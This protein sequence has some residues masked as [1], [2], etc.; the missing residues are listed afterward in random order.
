MRHK[1]IVVE[2]SSKNKVI[3]MTSQ[4]E[5]VKIPFKK[6]VHVGQE[7]RYKPGKERLNVWQLGLAVTLFLAMVGTW[8]IFSQQFFPA[9]MTPAYI[10]TL[11]FQSSLELQVDEKRKVLALTG[12]NSEGKKLASTLKVAGDSLP[13]ALEK[14]RTEAENIGFSQLGQNQMVATIASEHNPTLALKEIKSTE[15]NAR[16][17]GL[18]T[19]IR[20]AFQGTELSKVQVWEVPITLQEE[21]RLADLTPSRYL[22]LQLPVEPNFPQRSEVRLTMNDPDYVEVEEKGSVLSRLSTANVVRPALVPTRWTNKSTDAVRMINFGGMPSP[23][24][25]S[26]GDYRLYQ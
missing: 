15:E 9:N 4:G 7:I 23:M 13:V 1:G 11:D 14:I 20:T 8:P 17:A 2:I 21:A 24:A 22:A 18:D 3:V 26:E 12:L 25:A 16:L 19:M 10:I 6:H 5:F